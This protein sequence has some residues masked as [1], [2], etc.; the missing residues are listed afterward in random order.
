MSDSV[1][2]SVWD[3]V[4]ASVNESGYGQH[5]ASWL[6]FYEYFR[7]VVGLTSQTEKLA[8]LIEHAKHGG[9]YLPYQNICWLSERPSLLARD[10]NGRLHSLTGPSVLYPDGWAIY[11]VHGVRVPEYVIARPQLISIGG[12]KDEANAEI[13]RVMIE[14]YGYERYINDANLTKVD[15]CAANHGLIGLRTARLFRDGDLAVLDVLNSTPEPDGTTRR[16]AIPVDPRAYDGRA[17]KECLAALTSTWRKRGDAT[18][19][20]FMRPE[21]Y[22]PFAES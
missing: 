13:R 2:G 20:F 15:E 21:D 18:Q 22:A 10:T 11:A 7:E 3:Y 16:Y 19:L 9:W 6:G 8:G 5:D 17:G 14:R 12:I 1:S 4:C